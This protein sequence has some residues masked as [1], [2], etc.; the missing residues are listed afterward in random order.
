MRSQAEQL[1]IAIEDNAWDG[2]WYLRAWFDDGTPLGSKSNDECTIDSLSQ[3]WAVLSSSPPRFGEGAGGGVERLDPHPHPLPP[4]RG[5]GDQSAPSPPSMPPSRVSSI[6]RI[7]W[8]S[9]SRRR[10]TRAACSRATSRAMC[11][12]SAK[13]AGNTRTR[14][15]G[16]CKRS[17]ASAAAA[18]RMPSGKCSA[19]SATPTRPNASHATRS[20]RT[21]SRPTC[22]ACRRT[23]AA[24]AGRGTPARPSWLYRAALE[25]LLGFDKRGNE[26]RFDPRI[27]ASWPGFEIEYRHGTA[28]YRCRI[29]NPNGVEHGVREVWVDGERVLGNVIALNDDGRTHEVRVAM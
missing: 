3:S 5:R 18:R 12:A 4:R 15:S 17:P 16:S 14:P 29:E 6:A 24:A 19:R 22:T 8:S 2:D 26:L 20:S 9:Y 10:S 7:A 27:P 23:S 28:T 21:S 1:R 11:R 25:T 13:T